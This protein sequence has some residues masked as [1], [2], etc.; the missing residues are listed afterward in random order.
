[1]TLTLDPA[2]RAITVEETVPHAADVVWKVLT[3]PELIER[4]LMR[5]D[6]A[7]VVGYRFTLSG[8][9]GSV[10][11]DVLAVEP[12]KTLTYTWN[13]PHADP[14][15]DLRSVVSFTLTPTGSGTLLRMEQT[16]FRPNQKQAYGGAHAGW[17]QFFDK[18]DELVAR[19]E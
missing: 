12:G 18:L 15:F 13:H 3:T 7:P 9:W 6:F 11:C 19:T 10:E 1:M 2:V 17:K 5:N 14:A 16:G 8:D 4:W